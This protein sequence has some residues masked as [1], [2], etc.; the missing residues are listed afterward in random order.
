MTAADEIVGCGEAVKTSAKRE[1]SS[2]S[3]GG[4]A[5]PT[6][7]QSR[8]S[9]RRVL[10][11]REQTVA[12]EEWFGQHS[13]VSAPDRDRLAARLALRPAQV[14]IWFQNRRYK[15]KKIRRQMER[16]RDRATALAAAATEAAACR[17]SA[18]EL[19]CLAGD[20]R[21]RRAALPPLMVRRIAVPILVRDGQPCTTLINHHSER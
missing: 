18:D 21:E 11:S 6:R 13:Y 19:I 17:F 14:K 9:R 16:N 1:S 2:S 10:F 3:T 5:E 4:A 8:R 15:L 7:C 20:C 12:L